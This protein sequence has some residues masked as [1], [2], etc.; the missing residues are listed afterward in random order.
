MGSLFREDQLYSVQKAGPARIGRQINGEASR[1][2]HKPSEETAMKPV[3][4]RLRYLVPFPGEEV[5]D[6]SFQ[7]LQR[8]F[9]GRGCGGALRQEKQLCA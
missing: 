1:Q 3:Q 4:L 8:L 9:K 6:R 5:N 7:S 2:Q